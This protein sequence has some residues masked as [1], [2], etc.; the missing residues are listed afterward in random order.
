MESEIL[1]D[2]AHLHHHLD[3]LTLLLG[4]VFLILLFK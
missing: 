2:L 1:K 4:L 3:A